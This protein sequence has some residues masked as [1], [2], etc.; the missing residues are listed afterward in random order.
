MLNLHA[1]FHRISILFAMIFL[2][3]VALLAF[4][5]PRNVEAMPNFAGTIINSDIVTNTTWTVAGSPYMVSV[6]ISVTD[7]VTLTIEPNVT[8]ILSGNLAIAGK[9]NAFGTT[10][11]PITFTSNATSLG[12]LPFLIYGEQ[13]SGDFQ[14]AIFKNA[15][16]LIEGN[17]VDPVP[18]VEFQGVMFKDS[19][20]APIRMS[21]AN[22]H[23]LSLSN[24]S[25]A[26]NQP[27]RI[28]VT[29]N[30]PSPTADR[31]K[32]DV[33]LLPH[34]GLEGYEF[35]SNVAVPANTTMTISAGTTIFG[36]IHRGIFVEGGNLVANGSLSEPV[37]FTADS[38]WTVLW[39]S[40][41]TVNLQNSI[42]EKV[43][44]YPIIVDVEILHQLH[45]T[46]VA[47]ANNTINRVKI[48]GDDNLL[49]V[50]TASVTLTPQPGLEGYEWGHYDM[51]T[52]WYPRIPA[53][54]TLTLQPSATLILPHGLT[55]EGYLQAIGA[56]ASPITITHNSTQDGAV[57][58]QSGGK[59][60]LQ[61]VVYEMKS[62]LWLRENSGQ[63]QVS[64][65]VIQNSGWMGVDADA[66]A[67]H[68]LQME[69]VT[70]VNNAFNRVFIE[71]GDLSNPMALIDD[72]WLTPQNNLEGYQI[73]S[74]NFEP[75]HNFNI[76]AGIT[77]TVAPSVTVFLGTNIKV[78]GKLQALGIPTS[79][80][81]FTSATSPP[82]TSWQGIHL[83]SGEMNVA[84]ANIQNVDD[85][86]IVSNATLKLNCVQFNQNN[87]GIWVE[88]WGSSEVNMVNGLFAGNSIAGLQN[89]HADQIDARYSWWGDASGPSGIG[90]GSGDVISGNVSYDP[91]LTAP[92]C[93]YITPQ[94]LDQSTITLDWQSHQNSCGYQAYRST[95]PY[96]S[97]PAEGTLLANLPASTTSY[98]D[99]TSD[100]DDYFY[101]VL[102]Q[103]CAGGEMPANE[104]GIFH[105]PIIP[106]SP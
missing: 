82:A 77:L 88:N 36:V 20:A 94:T 22:L 90:A 37:T 32:E 12:N 4:L 67:I 87:R 39:F 21:P 68:Q 62:G 29:H 61:H 38:I 81:T 26:N 86:I 60:N 65:A 92:V 79:P 13:G 18:M 91:W 72:V 83:N 95:S 47:F 106:G 16:I 66:S 44:T 63:V 85:G 104:T 6:P 75:N 7:N 23:R 17:Y 34:T 48:D 78:E 102:T 33:T 96:F 9:I 8:V 2:N 71:I 31:I 105:F 5:S 80:I 42:I 50:P 101:H 97:P 54:I 3:L 52:L 40:S 43:N 25:F 69:N 27:N 10:I 59:G 100:A 56:P 64:D 51:S 19:L 70:F 57:S 14:Q 46:N 41:G 30:L 73:G 99:P 58:F 84:Y 24:S 28:L 49:D 55:M 15:P 53:G 93:T 1:S 89:D 35:N 45:M 11:Q 74:G 98:H 76:P 103:V